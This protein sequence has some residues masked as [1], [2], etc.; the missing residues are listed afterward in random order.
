MPEIVNLTLV[1]IVGIVAS[2]FSASVGGSAMISIPALIFLGLPPQIAIATDRLGGLGSQATSL[3]KFWKAEK[4]VW[5]FTPILVGVS[6]VGSIIGANILLS[7]DPEILQKLVGVLLLVFLPFVFFNKNIGI[8]R[9]ETS[10]L[11]KIIGYIVYFILQT[12]NSFFGVG[13]G[14]FFFYTLVLA[15]GLSMV[16]ASATR[17]I[18]LM[19]MAISSVVIFAHKGIINYEVGIV[20]LVG[21]AIGGYIGAHVALKKGSAWIKGLFAVVVVTASIKLLL[22]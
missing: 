18:P 20:L 10:K 21:M 15:F 13:V 2:F 3:Y 14:P 5:V 12:F 1:F 16:E 4:I 11:K 19:T 8:S 9:T 17:V 22:F 6:L 7:V